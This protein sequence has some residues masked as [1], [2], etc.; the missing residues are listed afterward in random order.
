MLQFTHV[1]QRFFFVQRRVGCSS[2]ELNIP[3][4]YYAYMADRLA[5]V[6]RVVV[7]AVVDTIAVEMIAVV[8]VLVHR[9]KIPSFVVQTW[10]HLP[11]LLFC[12]NLS[13]LVGKFD[14]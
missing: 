2:V 10:P 7:L 3:L 4:S 5:F 8:L 1:S 12:S 11:L 6:V 13:Y 9:A 14:H